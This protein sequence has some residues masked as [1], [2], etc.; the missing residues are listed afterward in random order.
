MKTRKVKKYFWIQ[1]LSGA[2]LVASLLV[3]TQFSPQA[4]AATDSG[5]VGLEGKISAPPPKRG[6]TIAFPS[7]DSTITKSPITVT[8]ICPDGLLVKIFKNN[9]FSGSAIC[10]GG[11]YSIKIDLFGGRNEIVARVYD[12]LDQ[13]GPDSNKIVVNYPVSGFNVGRRISL[14]SS[15]AKRGA[16]PG[17][18]LTWPISL[19]GGTGPYAIT[20]DWGDGKAPDVISQ[21]FAGTF[22]IK[23][24][25]DNAGVYIITVRA[26]DKNG[27][28]AFLQLV[29]VGNGPAAQSS[30]AGGTDSGVAGGPTK[31]KILWQPTLII[32]PLLATSFW[33]GRRHELFVLRK[34]LERHSSI[35]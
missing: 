6:A 24:V 5:S 31:T 33:L 19:S 32:L 18:D 16:N 2:A 21:Q 29:G 30:E 7:T 8:G 4:F 17:S 10:K 11:S 27:D 26:S 3:V 14:T 23:H 15:F 25:Y 1:K 34:R 13:A 20:V 28:V 9:V 12:E 22:N 35:E